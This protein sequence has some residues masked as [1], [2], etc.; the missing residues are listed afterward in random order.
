MH[1]A[2]AAPAS[3]VCT[4]RSAGQGRHAA[5]MVT[6]R[7]WRR[8]VRCET[9]GAGRGQATVQ[10]LKEVCHNRQTHEAAKASSVTLSASTM[11]SAV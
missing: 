6:Q 8:L 2:A 10:T 3:T 5:C 11:I 9:Q 7:L 4:W 1:A